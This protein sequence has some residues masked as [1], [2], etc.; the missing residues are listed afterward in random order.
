MSLEEESYA[1]PKLVG[2]PAYAR[3]APPIDPAERPFD[4]DELPILAEQTPEE[5]ALVEASL[6]DGS[7]A[8]AR[9]PALGDARPASPGPPAPGAVDGGA[10]GTPP[11]G[12]GQLLPRSVGHTIR[13]LRERLQRRP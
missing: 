7:P 11:A 4:P 13:G 3:P 9:P 1:L 2:A 10:D 8:A 6:G 5:R 12:D